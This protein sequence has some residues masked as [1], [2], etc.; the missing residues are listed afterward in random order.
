MKGKLCLVTGAN[1]GIGKAM[2]TE[3]ARHGADVV[4]VCRSRQ[5]GEEALAD[6]RRDSGSDRVTLE[7]ADVGDMDSI[8]A[9]VERFGAKGRR[10]DVLANNAG[11]Y[12]PT[13]TLTKQGHESMLAIN[14]LGPF[15][16]TNLLLDRLEG[17]RVITTS[18]FA[19]SWSKLDFDDLGCARS[20]IP[21]RHYGTTKL[22]N[23]LFTRELARRE[24]GR[25][26][27][28][29]CF[30]PGAVG[31]GFGQDEPGLLSVGMKIVKW[32]MLTPEQGADTGVFLA[33][34]DEALKSNGQYWSKR[35]IRKPWGVG[36]DDAVAARLWSASA[37]LV[38]LG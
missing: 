13:H 11:V 19:H 2:A 18:S 35:K 4:M 16:M 6:I 37:A 22:M 25:G 12:L 38:G 1:S 8:R 26:I 17:A 24:G 3:L 14:H 30:H 31:T 9:F 32:A 5:R 21:L 34:S 7:L 15:L 23:I 29:H 28:A 36:T 27:V 10:I 33:T 20:F